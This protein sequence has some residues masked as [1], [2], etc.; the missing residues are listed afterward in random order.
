M[1]MKRNIRFLALLMI[2]GFLST[3]CNKWIDPDININPDAPSTVTM[4]TLLPSIMANVGYTTVGGTDVNMPTAIWIQQLAGIDRQAAAYDNYDFK[5]GDCNN[6]WNSNY[7]STMMDIK[8]FIDLANA[9]NSPYNRGIGKVL[10]AI[11]LGMTTDLWGDIPYT[12]AFQ[13]ADNLAPVFDNQQAVYTTI[14]T[15]LD[16]AIAD[17]EKPESENEVDVVG[18]L[19][20]DGD[21]DLWKEAAYGLKARYAIHL[22]EVNGN[23]AYTTAFGFIDKA[24]SSNANTFQIPF[25]ATPT[26]ANPL[27]QYVEQRGD[28]RMGKFFIDLLKTTNDPRIAVY[29]AQVGGDYVGSGPG[30][31]NASAS[32]LGDAVIAQDAPVILM[33]YPEVLFIKAECDY[34]LGR[35]NDAKGSLKDAV[36][37]SLDY[38]GVNNPTWKTAFDAVIDGLSGANLY[39]AIVLQKYIALFY[40]L[41]AYN[42]WRRTNN[43]IGL[44]KNQFVP[45]AIPNRYPYPQEEMSFNKNCPKNVLI[46]DKIWWDK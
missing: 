36:A 43:E 15:L 26:G 28:I 8:Q 30:E 29:A 21:V 32:N 23:S 42:D 6:L 5:A 17:F 38:W 25:D 33:S 11:S 40:Q 46:S 24:I 16:E 10:M 7:S 4:A 19:I 20:Y 18:D 14:Q 34:K 2:A 3:S 37:A 12:E 31:G 27:S 39:K 1:K 45:T 41:E 35:E 9:K 13:G 44:V 22:S